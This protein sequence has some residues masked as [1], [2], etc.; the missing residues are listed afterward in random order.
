MFL[1][2]EIIFYNQLS[3]TIQSFIFHLN[4]HL[5]GHTRRDLYCVHSRYKYTHLQKS[6]E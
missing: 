3:S 6:C 4:C 5:E 1:Y 2:K